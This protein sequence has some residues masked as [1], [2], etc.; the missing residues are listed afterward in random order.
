MD[1]RDPLSPAGAATID[2]ETDWPPAITE[3]IGSSGLRRDLELL[4][5]L[6]SD[7]ARQ[8]GGLGV[9][10]L[11][12]MLQ[13]DKSQVSRALRALEQ[14]ALVE[15]DPVT[16]E[17]R[18][19]WLLFGLAARAGDPRLLQL[20]PAIL[21]EL[22]DQLGESMHLCVLQ[23]DQVLTVLTEAPSHSFRASGWVGRAIPAHC[24]SA[25][26]VLLIDYGCAEL[27]RRFSGATFERVGPAQLVRSAADL[28]QQVRI[29]REAGYAIVREEFEP[30]LVGASAPV[31]DFRGQVV[32]ALNLSAP[33]FRLDAGLEAAARAVASGA[34]RLSQ[35]LGWAGGPLKAP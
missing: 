13:R 20:A 4:Q 15:R 23:A 31:R 8:R 16:R 14:A 17:Y 5:A 33:K 29:A 21:R 22:V 25:G 9:V 35:Q 34:Q 28:C 19:G 24:S 26:R 27:A 30:D 3:R 2:R 7:E 10:R 1:L 6:A 11:A 18:L 32:A 12:E